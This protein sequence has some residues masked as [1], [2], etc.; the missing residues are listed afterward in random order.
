MQTFGVPSGICKYRRPTVWLALAGLALNSALAVTPR[1]EEFAARARWIDQVFGLQTTATVHLQ[2]GT[3]LR[4]Q[5]L[6]WSEASE[7]NPFE[8][9][10]RYDGRPSSVLMKD[11]KRVATEQ[12]L[13]PKGDQRE[14]VYRESATGLEVRLVATVFQ[15]FPA[16][17]WV[18]SLRNTGE[19]KTPI[20]ESI[21]ALDAVIPVPGDGQP[22]L[23]WAKG[24][25]ASFDDFAPQAAVLRPGS[26]LRLQPGGGRSS[27]QV[28]P[29]FNLA[30]AGGG[31]VAGIGWTGEWAAE[32]AC[33]ARGGVTLRSG[34]AKTHLRL[35]AGEQ[36][37]TPRV[38]LLFYEGDRWRGQN[39]LRQFLLVHH[40]PLLAGEPLVAP[41]T[42]GNWGGTRAE[43]HLDNIQKII[44]HRLPLD[45]Y[46]IDAEWY[47]RTT[48][49]GSWP[50]NVGNWEVKRTLYPE[51]FKPLSDALRASGRRLMLWFEPERVFKG[52]PW[53]NEHRQ[54]LL[55]GGGDSLLFN[56]GDPKARQF[57]TEF[58]S[59]KITEFGI[60]CYR[61]DFNMDPLPFWQKTDPPDRV[62]MSEIR[63]IEGLYAFW[64][65]LRARHPDLLIDNCASGG[66]RLDLETAGRAT[67]FWR[68]DGPRD[69]IAHQCHTYGLLAWWPMSATSQDR[70]LDDYE[71]RSS[72]CSALCLNWWVSGDAPAERIPESFP[73]AWARRTLEQYQGLRSFYYGDYYPLT[74]YSQ[75]R[76]V[77]M[78][79][80]LDRTDQG[81]GLVVALRRPA[82]PYQSARLVLRELAENALYKVRDLDAKTERTYPGRELVRDGLEISIG[83]RPGS[84]LLVYERQGP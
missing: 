8:V 55:D 75:A 52:T 14:I 26:P 84:A 64:D 6:P 28:M 46:W 13:G 56:L 47:G 76:D 22:T 39:L 7:Y 68:T 23:H 65:G 5:D 63:H 37:R 45:Y 11:W 42:C 4:L 73:F 2:D 44:Q 10:F 67:P 34:L 70:A 9:S 72:M 49:D 18:A 77:W 69:P 20:L 15:D 29:F 25:V 36:I 54:W 38:L 16:V 35:E 30:G 48:G 82:S 41:I 74:E 71:F 61:Q 24:G 53:F 62:G 81:Q 33:S 21:Q 79:Y 40:R 58:I 50:V 59:S 60:G 43:I 32:F 19:S 3:K 80:Q 17:E 51:G 78:A 1:P 83:T 27:S 31:V 66:R 57:L 12:A